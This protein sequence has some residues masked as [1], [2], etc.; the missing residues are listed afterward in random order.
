MPDPDPLNPPVPSVPSDTPPTQ[1][2]SDMPSLSPLPDPLPPPPPAVEPPPPPPAVPENLQENLEEKLGYEEP[3]PA[4]PV[5]PAPAVDLPNGG[6]KKFGK[7]LKTALVAGLVAIAF[8]VVGGG[9]FF[10][11][12]KASDQQA[13]LDVSSKAVGGCS[14]NDSTGCFEGDD[15]G[16]VYLHLCPNQ[17][18]GPC[19]Q[20]N[21][22]RSNCFQDNFCGT[23]QL[24]VSENSNYQPTQCLWCPSCA[25]QNSSPPV[26]AP[27]GFSCSSCPNPPSNTSGI[28]GYSDT[29]SRTDVSEATCEGEEPPPA[30]GESP[31]PGGP[32]GPP[33]APCTASE[34]CNDG[35]T[36]CGPTENCIVT[37]G[38]GEYPDDPSKWT[39]GCKADEACVHESPEPSHSPPPGVLCTDLR[40]NNEAPK[41]GDT[42]RLTCAS[43][44]SSHVDRFDFRYRIDGGEWVRLAPG[45]PEVVPN[46]TAGF[47]GRTQLTIEQAGNYRAQCRVCLTDGNAQCTDWGQ[48]H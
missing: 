6:S 24:D 25:S 3:P 31:P 9:V 48:A 29:Q 23:Q 38:R 18:G 46:A 35:K 45:A 22:E 47:R 32:P 16:V 30:P 1:P 33:P 43:R 19:N 5:E 37:D 20:Q 21:P 17:N 11:T 2:A 36:V 7:G 12:Q 10:A 26:G 13:S 28:C 15:C 44:G 4:P 14:F 42:V 34:T 27:A 39:W 8:V 41:I 40:T